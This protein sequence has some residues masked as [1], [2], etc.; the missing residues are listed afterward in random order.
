MVSSSLLTLDARAALWQADNLYM[1]VDAGAV[2]QQ[3]A[4]LKQSINGGPVSSASATFDTGFRG[5]VTLGYN[6]NNA[7]AVE[8]ETG[9]IWNSVDK[10]GG[11]KLDSLNQRLELYQIPILVNA[12]YKIPTSGHWTPYFGVGAGG[13]VNISDA[14]FPGGSGATEFTFAYQAEA[15]VN[16]AFSKRCSANLAYKFFGT[17]DP[18]WNWTLPA[19]GGTD[20]GTIS[21]VYTHSLVAGITWTF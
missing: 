10:V 7:W 8:L 18:S 5:D 9:V 17:L 14:S 20:H 6:L 4:T 2:F 3:D 16:Y 1:N 19:G 11:V 21:G 13:V 12:I 15:G